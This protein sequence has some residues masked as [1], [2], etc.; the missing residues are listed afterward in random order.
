MEEDWNAIR[1]ER[2]FPGIGLL[3]PVLLFGSAAIALALMLVPVLE[4]A[5]SDMADAAPLGLDLT[6]TGSINSAGG[7]S[8]VVRRSVLQS[9]PDAVCVIRAN[10]ARVG[11]C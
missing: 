10:G 9:S 4:D 5:S 6:S 8:Y 7:G 3:R 1:S 11:D 2:G